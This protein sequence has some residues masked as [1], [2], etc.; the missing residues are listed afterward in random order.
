MVSL[1]FFVL[2]TLCPLEVDG[3]AVEG[4]A[5]GDEEGALEDEAPGAPGAKKDG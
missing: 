2:D 1:L 5:G 3:L 4:P